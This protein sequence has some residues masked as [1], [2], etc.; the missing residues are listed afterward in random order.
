MPFGDDLAA[1]LAR[2]RTEVDQMVGAAD[3]G[4]GRARP[5][6][7]CCRA[8]ARS[9]SSVEQPLVVLRMQPDGRLVEHVEGRGQARAER[10]REVDALR[11]A[12]R[13]RARL[14]VERQVVEADAVQHREPLARSR[15][16]G[17][18]RPRARAR[19]DASAANQARKVLDRERR[20]ARAASGPA[21]RHRQRLGVQP[22]AAAVG[23]GVVGAV[24]RQQHA[25]VDACRCG[26]RASG[27]TPRGW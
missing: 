10:R 18:R 12:A 3:D 20:A 11:L 9:R 25:H 1:A 2:R 16:R 26:P 8:R 23:A 5:P 27:R 13:E 15:R 4:R 6:A 19:R 14:A 21:K 24:A 17:A 7:P 22:A